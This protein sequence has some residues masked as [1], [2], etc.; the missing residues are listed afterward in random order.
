MPVMKPDPLDR[1]SK[2]Y[3]EA[4]T[5]DESERGAFPAEA[6]AGS[7]E[8][9]GQGAIPVE[10]APAAPAPFSNQTCVGAA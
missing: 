6:C 2:I 7:T 3:H 10:S 8:S 4:L 1:I 5:R 9:E